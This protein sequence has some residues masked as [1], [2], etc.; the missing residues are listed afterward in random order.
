MLTV[1]LPST[2]WAAIFAGLAVLLVGAMYVTDRRQRLR[3]GRLG[4][5]RLDATA[6]LVCAVFLSC[7]AAACALLLIPP[8]SVPL[9]WR[10]VEAAAS[11]TLI[12]LPALIYLARGAGQIERALADLALGRPARLP[13]QRWWFPL[14][15]LIV[16]V[17]ALAARLGGSPEAAGTALTYREELLRQTREAAARE[18]RNRLARELHDSIK[19]Q[20]FSISVS[21]AAARER[22]AGTAGSAAGSAG[23]A[24]DALEDVRRGAREAQVEME[25]LLQQLRPA[26][27]EN[28]GL[29]EALRIQCEALGYR[30]G[31]VVAFQ[32]GQFPDDS[33]LA[34]GTADAI[35]RIAQEA[36]A[37]IARHAR[38]AHIWL[39]LGEVGDD[40]LLEVRDDGQGFVPASAPAGMGLA[41]MRQ[42]AAAL[43]GTAQVESAPG[44]GTTLRVRVP[45]LDPLLTLDGAANGE[46]TRERLAQAERALT[47]GISGLQLTGLFILTGLPGWVVVLG[48]A[49]L[50]YGYL[51][52]WYLQQWLERRLGKDHPHVLAVRVRELELGG[53]L[54][55]LAVAGAWYTT[56]VPRNGQHPASQMWI[57]VG[58]TV[59][60][61]AL[62]IYWFVRWYRTRG[63]YLGLL[64]ASAL[65]EQ[66]EQ[67]ERQCAV[68]LVVW[69]VVIAL[70]W[71]VGSFDPVLPPHSYGQWADLASLLILVLLPLDLAVEYAQTWRWKRRLR[72]KEASHD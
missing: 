41:N 20:L 5:A 57:A 4:V 42:R 64:R 24:Q 61:G 43:G 31:A 37:N 38:A 35:F 45:L 25:A 6:L 40:L 23:G 12:A 1:D 26:P 56:T 39:A 34:P 62:A 21:A 46:E 36:L 32:P 65:R 44:A 10:V 30:T 66:V 13:R 52:A 51:R 69:L 7:L 27:L 50:G 22:L 47:T 68:Y 29:V 16:Q 14:T 19:Q 72:A 60:W 17:R 8:A 49:V 58:G 59:L 18:E 2:T 71:I 63:R 3:A 70:I 55:L 67:S 11:G 33:R 54:Y 15:G 9:P 53:W 28:V 48:V